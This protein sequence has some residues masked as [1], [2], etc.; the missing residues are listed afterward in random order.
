[1]GH[2]VN[3]LFFRLGLS[4]DWSYQLRDP[5]LMNIFIYRLIRSL[6][7]Q[8]SAPYTSY[9]IKRN[10]NELHNY[11]RKPRFYPPNFKQIT[12][13][14][15]LEYIAQKKKLIQNPYKRA[16]F[17]FSHINVSRNQNL[18]ISI[19][20]FDEAAERYRVRNRLPE[21]Y[22]YCL[23]G[24]YYHRSHRWYSL[25]QKY[26]FHS[27]TGN[28]GKRVFKPWFFKG[29]RNFVNSR[30]YLKRVKTSLNRRNKQFRRVTQFERIYRSK[31]PKKKFKSKK[32]SYSRLRT[33]VKLKFKKY[34]RK[35]GEENRHEKY[36]VLLRIALSKERSTPLL[37]KQIRKHKNKI[38][39]M[40]KEAIS[41]Q[42]R[43]L[44]TNKK[45]KIK[46]ALKHKKKLKKKK[47]LHTRNKVKRLESNIKKNR[48]KN[49]PKKR[50]IKV[51]IKKNRAYNKISLLWK[52]LYRRKSSYLIKSARKIIKNSLK[53]ETDEFNDTLTFRTR[54]A[55]INRVGLAR[56]T[57]QKPLPLPLEFSGIN[58]LEYLNFKPKKRFRKLKTKKKKKRKIKK[59]SK[60]E[61]EKLEKEKID[62][63]LTLELKKIGE[64]LKK[65]W[66]LK[67]KKKTELKG[68]G[69]WKDPKTWRNFRRYLKK[70][71]KKIDDLEKKSD[72]KSKTEF[73]K[74]IRENSKLL[75]YQI[76][77]H[78]YLH[79]KKKNQLI[80]KKGIRS[81]KKA[82]RS[83]I[84]K[85]RRLRLQK[86]YGKR[87]K[88]RVKF[89][90]KHKLEK[91]KKESKQRKPSQ[92]P[93]VRSRITRAKL[94]HLFR[95]KRVVEETFIKKRYPIW[96]LNSLPFI[97][98]EKF[99]RH[100]H[101]IKDLKTLTFLIRYIKFY[102][103]ILLKRR[104]LFF[105]LLIN[106]LSSVLV[107]LPK[108]KI[109]NR[110]YIFMHLCYLYLYSF[111]YLYFQYNKK[112]FQSR[113]IRFNLLSK[114]LVFSLKKISFNLSNNIVTLRYYGLHNRN[115]NA[116]FLLNYLLVK[117]GQYY[118][119]QQILNPLVNNLKRMPFVK[120]FRFI[121][122]GRLTRKERAFFIVKSARRMPLS[123]HDSRIDSAADFKIMKFGV[124]GIKIYLLYKDTPPF[125]Y[126]FEFKNKI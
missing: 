93:D 124:V 54:M 79:Y 37:F 41:Y 26:H 114:L 80:M 67:Q 56:I 121:V 125:Y 31:I 110:L 17:T 84:R 120:G 68:L 9:Q 63:E 102:N 97:K 50:R 40:R 22:F 15:A 20:L 104:I 6:V 57:K 107:V 69:S 55:R 103:K 18:F 61:Q 108:G 4:K 7:F 28:R 101:L 3:P 53:I 106:C 117:L 119:I 100:R 52:T 34:D 105:N 10:S 116:Q 74:K 19:F 85:E 36:P 51:I 60:L 24:K 11:I 30:I 21:K 66:E 47:N 2:R 13:P 82:I 123:S 32:G 83:R 14:Q 98:T 33:Q 86:L 59:I 29:F 73:S 70:Q 65:E 88:K 46:I 76:Q 112:I 25:F 89:S 72:S 23:S 113:F 35:R 77:L 126:F 71:V 118:K 43:F 42:M 75:E 5:L 45:R 115:Y 27:S 96:L 95:R 78:K 64:E 91:S 87:K 94:R 44:R 12:K 90:K 38:V 49:K 81:L 58:I 8:Y 62:M 109:A 39:V 16:S 1:M 111:R 122:S 92:N 99:F 48:K